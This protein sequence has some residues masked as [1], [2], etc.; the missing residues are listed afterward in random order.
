MVFTTDWYNKFLLAENVDGKG[1][2]VVESVNCT[3]RFNV[4]DI[5]TFKWQNFQFYP[6]FPKFTL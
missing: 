6:N 4:N 2:F 3:I 1:L 5:N